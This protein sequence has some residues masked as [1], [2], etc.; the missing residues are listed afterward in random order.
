MEHL[1]HLEGLFAHNVHATEKEKGNVEHFL[2]VSI[3][4]KM[5]KFN[6]I[7]K[8]QFRGFCLCLETLTITKNK[9]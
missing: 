4:E 2:N 9:S 6:K 3:V 5:I 7:K 1:K 8:L